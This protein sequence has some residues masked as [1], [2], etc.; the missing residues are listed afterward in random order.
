MS[1]IFLQEQNRSGDFNK[2]LDSLVFLFLWQ[3]LRLRLVSLGPLLPAVYAF[4]G[5][6]NG[7][8]V[9]HLYRKPEIRVIPQAK[10]VGLRGSSIILGRF[11]RW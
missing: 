2:H 5:Q 1:V 8:A 11:L 6:G 3:L 7:F 4:H 10:E 9:F